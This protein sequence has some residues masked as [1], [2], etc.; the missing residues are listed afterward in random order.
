MTM[1]HKRHID[2]ASHGHSAPDEGGS[3]SPTAKWKKKRCRQQHVS[4]ASGLSDI[5]TNLHQA[6]CPIIHWSDFPHLAEFQGSKEPTIQSP[7][8]T[9]KCKKKKKKKMLTFQTPEASQDAMQGHH[10]PNPEPA[11]SP[12]DLSVL[13]SISVIIDATY[14]IAICIDCAITI[15]TKHVHSHAVSH[16]G[17]KPPLQADVTRILES[18][19]CVDQFTP[20]S[21]TMVPIVGLKVLHGQLCLMQDCGYLSAMPRTMQEHFKLTHKAQPWCPNSAEHNIQR[22]YEFCGNQTL[23]LVDLNLITAPQQHAFTDYLDKMKKKVPNINHD[24]YH[25]DSNT[26]KH[27]TFLAKMGWNK[28]IKGLHVTNLPQAVSSPTEHEQHLQILHTT[29]HNWLSVICAMLPNLDLIF[30][31]LI[32]TSKGFYDWFLQDILTEGKQYPFTT[33]CKEMHFLSAIAHSKTRLPNLLWNDTHTVLQ[34]DGSLLIVSTIRDMVKSLLAHTNQ[35]I[36]LLSE[37]INLANY[38]Q[39]LK[40]HLNARISQIGLRTPSRN[41]MMATPLYKIQTTHSKPSGCPPQGTMYGRAPVLSLNKSWAPAINSRAPRLGPEV[42]MHFGKALC[43]EDFS[44]IL[45]YQ[46]MQHLH[47]PMGLRMW[48]Q[49]IKAL[50]HHIVNIDI[51]DEDEMFGHTTS[52]GRSCY[53]PT[54]NDLPSLHK[55][56]IADLFKAVGPHPEISYTKIHEAVSTALGKLQLASSQQTTIIQETASS[57]AQVLEMLQVTHDK[58]DRTHQVILQGQHSQPSSLIQA[59]EPLDIGFSCIQGLHLFLQDSSTTFKS[60]QQVLAIEVIS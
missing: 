17:F 5:S 40:K 35:L 33:F 20:P 19:G 26:H 38:D 12:E 24:V 10:T 46:T 34:V 21:T 8:P 7:P 57:H 53:G 58:I 6:S 27:R 15:P 4:D 31:H 13:N 28:A 32:N 51:D 43:S 56:M 14:K 48:R 41:K 30:L 55:D 3:S 11:P 23:I 42:F 44:S 52:T 25:V 18:F 1:H 45:Q 29:V 16:H 54:W 36:V 47:I 9:Q 60:I 49:V 50:L 39:C 2:D 59:M 22:V 37:G